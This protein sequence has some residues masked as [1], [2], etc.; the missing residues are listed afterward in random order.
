MSRR[1]SAEF[2]NFFSIFQLPNFPREKLV[3]QS[4]FVHFGV[5]WLRIVLSCRFREACENQC[6]SFPVL[7]HKENFYA[8]SARALRVGDL[9]I[10]RITRLWKSGLVRKPICT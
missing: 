7:V 4:Y 6:T 9:E 8:H 5:A 2:R 3:I 1:V 10:R